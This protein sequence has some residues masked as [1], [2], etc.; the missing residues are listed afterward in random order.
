MESRIKEVE[1]KEEKPF[2]KIMK[3]SVTGKVILFQS[4][5]KG[6][7]VHGH[8]GAANIGEFHGYWEMSGFQ[9]FDGEV[10]LKN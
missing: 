4:P 10:T 3:S 8:S 1:S 7:L 6:V 9:D 2:P 5:G